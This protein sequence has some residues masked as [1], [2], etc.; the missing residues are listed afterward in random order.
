MKRYCRISR[1]NAAAAATQRDDKMAAAL[2]AAATGD[3]RSER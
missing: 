1:Q 3:G 2:R